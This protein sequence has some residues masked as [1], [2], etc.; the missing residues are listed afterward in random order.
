MSHS[1]S[2]SDCV[3]LHDI[4]PGLINNI[5]TFILVSIFYL[6][7]S[8]LHTA[9]SWSFK[10]MN[11]ALTLPAWATLIASFSFLDEIQIHYQYI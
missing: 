11:L 10:K 8:I 9:A 1:F 6:P 4:Q 5:I 3:G 7:R 2:D